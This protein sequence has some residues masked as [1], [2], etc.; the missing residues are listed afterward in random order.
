MGGKGL[1][2]RGGQVTDVPHFERSLKTKGKTACDFLDKPRRLFFSLFFVTSWIL[3]N[4]FLS[5]S[6][7]RHSVSGRLSVGCSRSDF[8]GA[9]VC[10]P[11]PWLL[12]TGSCYGDMEL[13]PLPTVVCFEG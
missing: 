9:L 13:S 11:G 4:H 6:E 10:G 5:E 8:Y 3:L 1:G 7:G 12:Q 2:A